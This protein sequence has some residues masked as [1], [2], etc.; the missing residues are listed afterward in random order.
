MNRKL[1]R[2][3]N[4]LQKI[5]KIIKEAKQRIDIRMSKYNPRRVEPKV[6][7]SYIKEEYEDLKKKIGILLYIIIG[8]TSIYVV[9]GMV[10]ASKGMILPGLFVCFFGAFMLMLFYFYIKSYLKHLEKKKKLV[11]EKIGTKIESSLEE[12][13]F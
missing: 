13:K 4:E 12:D 1:K 9:L 3:V 5:V 2:K 10:L 11:S 6:F 8:V 7:F